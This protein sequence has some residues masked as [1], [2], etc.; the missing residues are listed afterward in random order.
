[1]KSPLRYGILFLISILLGACE[2]VSDEMRVLEKSRQTEPSW[3]LNGPGFKPSAEGIDFVLLKDKVLDLTLGLSQAEASV[4]YNLKFQMYQ[5]ILSNVDQTQL[6]KIT[7]P[8]FQ[9]ELSKILDKELTKDNLKDFYFEKVSVPTGENGLIPEYYRIYAYARVD[10]NQRAV[11]T[12]SVKSYIQT[13]T[14]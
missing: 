8:T 13:S 6:G 3:L 5:L 11:I 4:L 10:A 12:S 14:H 9:K 7:A 1:M 2:T